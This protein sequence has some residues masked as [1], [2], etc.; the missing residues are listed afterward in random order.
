MIN[1]LNWLWNSGLFLLGLCLG[2]FFNVVVYR[3]LEDEEWVNSRSKCEACGKKLRWFDNIPLVSFLLLKGKCR[4]CGQQ[5]SLIHPLVELATGLGLVLTSFFVLRFKIPTSPTFWLAFVFW[6]LVFLASWLIFLFDL[7]AMII[8]DKLV[9]ILTLLGLL[10]TT[11][12]LTSNLVSRH[13]FF[14]NL[15]VT[16]ALVLF[17]LLLWFI[18]DKKGFGL[19]DVKLALPL[20]LILGYPSLIIGVFLAFIIGAIWGIIL[21]ITNKR[22]F[23][24]VIPFGPFLIVGFWFSLIW[25]QQLWHYYWYQ[26]II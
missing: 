2:S 25:G 19:G 22:K 16:A 17:F 12:E 15:V 3:T 7:K 4:S 26:L 13:Q 24:Q 1:N 23:G 11:L 10:K 6:S 9:W 8:P 18:T 5:I 14:L 21:I 20:G